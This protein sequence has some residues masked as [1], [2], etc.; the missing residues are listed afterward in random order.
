MEVQW[1]RLILL[2]PLHVTLTFIIPVLLTAALMVL[3]PGMRFSLTLLWFLVFLSTLS[4]QGYASP[5]NWYL[6][7]FVKS[8]LPKPKEL[9]WKYT[10]NSGF[11]H[12]EQAIYVWYPHGH[13]GIGAFGSIVGG[14]GDAIWKRPTALCVA[15]L[16]F[17]IPAFRH[18][19]LAFGLV[20]SDM[21]NMQ[22]CLSQGTSLVIL[23]G[24]LKEM[25]CS[26]NGKMQ[27]IDGRQGFLRLAR[28]LRR[29]LIPVF[30]YG[31]NE[32]FDGASEPWIGWLSRVMETWSSSLTMP[33]PASMLN[34]LRTPLGERP[35]KI[36]LGP[37]FQPS[38]FPRTI[39]AMEAEW[40]TH[41][42]LAYELDRPASSP[43][44]TWIPTVPKKRDQNSVLD[45][46]L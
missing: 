1:A 14:L 42:M 26:E 45:A 18:C 30:S 38:E 17:D 33:S 37:T 35:L 16:A 7:S 46:E 25:K 12:G 43:P 44:I 34:W 13:L 29:P 11:N 15:P 23:A 10:D 4:K 6:R 32:L 24:G 36:A 3:Y 21:E 5:N 22:N 9:G 27:L 8:L 2:W 41:V 20:R 28:K 40:K 31:E 19:S 39:E